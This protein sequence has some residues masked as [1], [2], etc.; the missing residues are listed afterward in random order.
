MTTTLRCFDNG[1]L[2]AKRGTMDRYTI[3]PPR[4][5]GPSYRERDGSWQALA[6]NSQ[7]FHGIGMH[8]SARPGHHLG[9]RVLL[10]QLPDD[11]QKFAKQAFPE[12]FTNDI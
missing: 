7:P 11:V 5:A 3:L 10:E 6:C 8:T 4:W 1:G 9:K 2:A 12:F